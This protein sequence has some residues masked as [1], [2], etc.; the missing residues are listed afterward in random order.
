MQKLVTIY[1][2]DGIY[3]SG[4]QSLSIDKRHGKVEEHLSKYLS[5]GWNVK[6]VAA[7]GGTAVEGS[8]T[9]WIIA[10]LEKEEYLS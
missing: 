6:S 3:Y 2:N 7:L 5:D 1:L 10:V 4:S 8:T 9:G